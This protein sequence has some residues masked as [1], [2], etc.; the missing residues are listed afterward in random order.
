MSIEDLELILQP[1]VED[2]KEAIGSMGDDTPTSGIIRQVQT[3][4]SFF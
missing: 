2:S 3:V 1:M 4:I